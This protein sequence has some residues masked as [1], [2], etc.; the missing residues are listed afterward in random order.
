MLA[1]LL[2]QTSCPLT[3]AVL[4]D[5]TWLKCVFGWP[6]CAPHNP[7]DKNWSLDSSYSFSNSDSPRDG[8]PHLFWTQVV[9]WDDLVPQGLTNIR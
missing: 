8:E 3:G 4:Y 1:T 6:A 7:H 9:N 2:E 5:F